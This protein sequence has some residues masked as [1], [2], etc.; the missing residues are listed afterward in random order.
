MI[1][2][3]NLA[4]SY[5]NDPFGLSIPS[6]SI[7]EG[8]KIAVTGPSGCGKT[9][10]L[11]LICGLLSPDSGKV[12][13]DGVDLTGYN[14]RD[15]QDFRIV[16]MGMIFQEFELL[17]YLT[18]LDNVLLPFRINGV[19]NLSPDIVKRAKELCAQVGLAD[20]MHKR[21]KTLSQGERQ[22]VAICRALITDPPVLLCDEPTANL[23]PENRD[24]ILDILF[25]LS[26]KENKSL[27]VVTHDQEVIQR[28]SRSI[29]IRD[30]RL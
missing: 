8:E 7:S 3:S 12:I 6:L 2:C 14:D 22:R 29:D 16:K 5:P 10:L 25:E 9:T 26:D 27:V 21:P 13:V 17:E 15:R 1:E 28:F 24:N 19:L 30:Y 23:D 18:L 4:F 11:N 20:M